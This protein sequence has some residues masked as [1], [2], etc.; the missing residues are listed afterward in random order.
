[1]SS[2]LGESDRVQTHQHE[3]KKGPLLSAL[4]KQAQSCYT[5]Q[6]T[7]QILKH[8]GGDSYV[9]TVSVLV[10]AKRGNS[11]NHPRGA[12][13][14]RNERRKSHAAGRNRTRMQDAGAA[15]L[16]G[17]A[18]AGAAGLGLSHTEVTDRQRAGGNCRGKAHVCRKRATSALRDPVDRLL[19]MGRRQAEVFPLRCPA[20]RRSTWPEF[21]MCAAVSR[22][23]AS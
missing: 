16:R 6:E 11:P 22:A 7:Q 5:T 23:S 21:S 19:R 9:R 10:R 18:D 1:M 3:R 17:R 8:A 12:G 20:P 14:V 15:P 2:G 4:F 13:Q